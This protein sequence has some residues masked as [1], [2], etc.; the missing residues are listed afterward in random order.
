MCLWQVCCAPL[1]SVLQDQASSH[2][3]D[4]PWVSWARG[5]EGEGLAPERTSNNQTMRCSWGCCGVKGWL[6]GGLQAKRNGLVD[7]VSHAPSC[8]LASVTCQMQIPFLFFFPLFL[9]SFRT[10]SLTFASLPIIPCS[11]WPRTGQ[12]F[13]RVCICAQVI[14]LCMSGYACVLYKVDHS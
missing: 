7:S 11:D 12:S 13:A 6:G 9:T 14:C 4:H 10:F 1:Q 2:G 5:A 3:P 8:S